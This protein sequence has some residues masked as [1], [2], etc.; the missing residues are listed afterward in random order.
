MSFKQH[1]QRVL[2]PRDGIEPS[3]SSR[4]VG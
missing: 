1:E 4:L 3:F 2:A